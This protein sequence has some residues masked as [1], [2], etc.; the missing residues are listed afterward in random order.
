MATLFIRYFFILLCGTYVYYNFLN[1]RKDK[2]YFFYLIGFIILD[3]YIISLF[4]SHNAIYRISIMFISFYIFITAFTKTN[5]YISFITSTISYALTYVCFNISTTLLCTIY[6]L[7]YKQADLIPYNQTYLPSGLL[8]TL[9]LICI[10]KIKRLRK[11]IMLLI[12]SNRIYIGSITSIIFILYIAFLSNYKSNIFSV[13]TYIILNCTLL[14]MSLLLL[15]YWHHRI[16]QTYREKLRLA[17]EKSLEDEIATLK[18]EITALQADNQRLRQIVHKDNKLVPAMEATVM[19]F[20]QSSGTLSAE[21]LSARGNELSSALHEMAL[22]RNGILTSLSPSNNGLPTSGLHTVDGLLS[23][24]EK[25]TRVNNIKYKV[26]IDDNINDL[27][28]AAISEEDLRHL[29]SDLIENAIIAITY[30]ELPGQISLHFGSLQNQFLLEISDN[31]IPFSPETY[32][33]FGNEQHTTHKADGGSGIGL[34]DIWKI[35]KQY[36]ASLQVFEYQ[37]GSN[38]FTKKISF[39]FDRKNHFLIQTYRDKELQATLTR[40]DAHVFP[41]EAD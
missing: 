39:V 1:C 25:R 40:G 29:L 13:R 5:M 22:E 15:Y 28:S 34:M 6:I 7:F 18:A 33:H 11:G 2:H 41:Y 36:K 30:A 27:I 19:D 9:L 14:F 37:T 23:Y 26:K 20:L 17:N 24:M 32:Q 3:S 38:I 35:K 10:M 16:T 4:F 21:E 31:G 8:H 12:H